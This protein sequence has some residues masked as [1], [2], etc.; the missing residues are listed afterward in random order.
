MVFTSAMDMKQLTFNMRELRFG[1]LDIQRA[2]KIA[3]DFGVPWSKLSTDAV[4]R[5]NAEAGN[6]QHANNAVLPRTMK[7]AQK[8]NQDFTRRWDP[9]LFL[10]FDNPVPENAE[11][12][13]Q[14]QNADLDRGVLTIN[15]VRQA[16]GL[17]EVKRGK[18]AW[19]PSNLIQ[20]G[21]EPPAPTPPPVPPRPP[22]EEEEE[23]EEEE[24]KAVDGVLLG[25]AAEMAEGKIGRYDLIEILMKAGWPHERAVWAT[26]V[27]KLPAPLLA[28]HETTGPLDAAW[29]EAKASRAAGHGRRL[30]RGIKLRDDLRREFREQ[31]AALLRHLKAMYAAARKTPELG[32]GWWTEPFQQLRPQRLG[33][34]QRLILYRAEILVA[35]ANGLELF[36]RTICIG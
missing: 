11:I 30:P 6:F 2:H 7:L 29:A 35:V 31:E 27:P 21:N 36:E 5:A 9:R 16:R 17:E 18:E 19:L 25:L 10:W 26:A 24:G 15:E 8:L 22:G 13:I 28:Y 23:A 12:A 32:A 1:E 20:V 14:Q 4:N 33:L 34:L 3:R